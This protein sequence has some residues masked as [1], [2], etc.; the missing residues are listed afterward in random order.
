MVLIDSNGI[1]WF[2]ATGQQGVIAQ[3][4][5]QANDDRW[6]GNVTGVGRGYETTMIAKSIGIDSGGHF[7][8]KL[9]GGNHSGSGASSQRWYDLG[10]RS[11]GD[12]Q[13]QW[14][15]PHPSNHDFS[16]PSSKN[17]ITNIGVG[18][19]GRWIGL[20]WLVYK[21]IPGGSPANGGVRCMMWVNTDCNPSTGAPNNSAWRLCVDFIDG[22]DEEVIDPQSFQAPD[23]CDLEIRRS[24]TD[25]H[26]IYKGGEHW[27]K[28]SAQDIATFEAGGGGTT[29]PPPPPGGTPNDVIGGVKMIYPPKQDGQSW[30]QNDNPEFDG[31]LI[32]DVEV[33]TKTSDY[34]IASPPAGDGEVYMKVTTDFGDNF[35]TCQDDYR[36]FIQSGN[37]LTSDDWKNV[38]VT[39]FVYPQ[40]VENTTSDSVSFAIDVRASNV[41]G[42]QPTG[43]C[44]EYRYAGV[45]LLNQSGNSAGKTRFTKVLG[46]VSTKLDNVSQSVK[47]NF[48]RSW[49]GFKFIVYNTKGPNNEDWVTLEIWICPSDSA[50]DMANNWTKINSFIDKGNNWG[51]GG[52]A[53]GGTAQQAITWGTAFIAMDYV[54]EPEIRWKK[55][56][57]REID[58]FGQW[59][60]DPDTDPDDPC[61]DPNNNPPPPP[62]PP[63]GG[64]SNLP[65][66]RF[67]SWGDNDTT[68]DATDVLDRIF[69]ETNVSQYLFAGDGPYASSAD[70]WTDMMDTYFST[71]ALKGQLMLAQGNHDHNESESNRTESDIEAWF[72]GLSNSKEGLE[73]LQQKKV[74]NAYIIVMN[75][76]DPNIDVVNGDQYNYVQNALNTAKQL[77]TSGQIDWIITMVH[78]SWFNLLGSNPSYVTVRHAYAAMFRDAQVDFMFHGHNHS[79]AIWR[80][81]VAIPGD[82]ENTSAQQLFTIGTDGRY[83]LSKD[84]GAFY[85]INGNGGHEINNWGED[86]ADFPNVLYANDDDFGYTVLDIQGK[87][88]TIIAKDVDGNTLFTVQATRGP[89]AAGDPIEDFEPS[90]L[91]VHGVSTSN[92]FVNDNNGVRMIYKTDTTKN[93]YFSPANAS[94]LSDPRFVSEAGGEEWTDNGDGTYRVPSDYEVAGIFSTS[95]FEVEHGAEGAEVDRL[96]YDY[97]ELKDQGYWNDPQTDFK[98][99][100]L[101]MYFKYIS[102]IAA[103]PDNPPSIG[104]LYGDLN[105]DPGYQ[106]GCGIASYGLSIHPITGRFFFAK[107]Q[108]AGGPVHFS[109]LSVSALG[110]LTGKTIGFCFVVKQL[111]AVTRLEVWIDKDNNNQWQ[112]YSFYEDSNNR[113]SDMDHCGASLPGQRMSWGTPLLLIN[114][115]QN[116]YDVKNVSAREII[117]QQL[118][119]PGSPPSSPPPGGDDDDECG[120]TTNPPP[121]PIESLYNDLTI[122]YNINS[123]SDGCLCNDPGFTPPPPPDQEEPC[124][125][126]QHRNSAGICVDDTVTPPPPPPPGGQNQAIYNVRFDGSGS[127]KDYKMG[128]EN[129]SSYYKKWGSIVL[130]DEA[131]VYG[132][133]IKRIEWAIAKVGNP[134][135][136]ATILIRDED[137]NIE[138][139]LG[140]IN[141]QNVTNSFQTYGVE[142]TST[143]YNIVEGD[144]ILIEY[145]GGDEDNYIIVRSKPELQNDM[146]VT[147]Q[148]VE[149]DDDEWDD[150]DREACFVAYA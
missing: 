35:A 23:E 74:G 83:D 135:G 37:V 133:N 8:S 46:N 60:S 129:R 36:D 67:I 91:D 14:E 127:N 30:F 39:I 76:Q 77:R 146:K 53:C 31:R 143:T 29:N 96:S 10:V 102:T 17:P 19:E 64:G 81:V 147:R 85:I 93:N 5:D 116:V 72:P 21:K 51:T 1:A 140:T 149:N 42:S 103:D 107:Q 112:F 56:S 137:D 55:W 75:S 49:T 101:K 32:S 144:R 4:R 111:V 122:I 99:V 66:Y 106:N 118:V 24:D 34:F 12:V 61:D 3:S 27:R 13:L 139:T 68:N 9:F 7:A 33:I 69:T 123:D 59:P 70:D 63:S 88:A 105:N 62:P 121:P 97:D 28:L 47:S 113:G 148:S 82:D 131:P 145:T 90:S 95:A 134:T 94:L 108:Y 141:V 40:E 104:F 124:P 98:N 71:P 22:I 6:S 120:G 125:S 50:N 58:P 18:L 26:E 2:C 128:D 80:P 84:H 45:L 86:P 110:D 48:Y 79:Y 87:Q 20:K 115:A 130:G 109:P 52:S 100:E 119:V 117:D 73:W 54:N 126:G 136:N 43:C 114:S 150:T 65:L 92:G 38:E 11:N 44:G 89:D 25:D 78:K 41:N 142:N 132:K 138:K 15:G 57:V 16:L